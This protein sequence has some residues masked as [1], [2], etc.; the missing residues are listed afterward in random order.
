MANLRW[1]W[2][3]VSNPALTSAQRWDMQLQS[4]FRTQ[5]TA[6]MAPS[7]PKQLSS[8]L[9]SLESNIFPHNSAAV[10]PWLHVPL[11][12]NI[13]WLDQH[14]LRAWVGNSSSAESQ[15]SRIQCITIVREKA[16][17]MFQ[18]NFPSVKECIPLL[19]FHF[20]LF[21]PCESLFCRVIRSSAWWKP[22]YTHLT[23]NISIYKWK[24]NNCLTLVINQC[25]ALNDL[26]P[27]RNSRTANIIHLG[28]FVLDWFALSA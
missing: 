23:F 21:S 2:N 6:L 20:V 10:A 24:A 1:S 12:T 19:I 3:S 13:I 7:N 9:Y 18:D 8:Y 15:K 22:F 5:C 27:T 25:Q 26:G 16:L 4:C 11:V 14:A 17:G 28:V